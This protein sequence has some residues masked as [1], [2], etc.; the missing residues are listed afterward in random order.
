[1]TGKRLLL[2]ALAVLIV[3]G[4]ACKPKPPEPPA[5][6][7]TPR[8]EV[9]TPEPED[10]TPPPRPLPTSDIEE[11]EIPADLVEATEWAHERGLLGV[12]YFP[13]DSSAL[14]GQATDRLSK[15]AAF[16]RE[17]PEYVVTV[18]GHCD[19]RGTNEYNI[20]LG[21]RRSDSARDFV[22]SQGI[23]GG[24]VRTVSLGEERPVCEDSSESCWR[25][26][27]RAYFKLSGKR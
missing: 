25:R 6:L 19:E 1:M 18:E 10:V 16:L 21:D 4:A 24:R 22:S 12:V 8:T 14:D 9:T 20:A 11:E 15:N 7:D 2:L 13:F 26:N 27:R 3:F 23:A 17:H 5:T